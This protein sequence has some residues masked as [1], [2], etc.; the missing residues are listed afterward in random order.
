[1]CGIFAVIQLISSY[2]KKPHETKFKELWMSGQSR[3]P[4]H[5]SWLEHDFG[6]LGFHR[7]A[8]NG[9]NT[10]SN[11]PLNKKGCI[12]IC[13]GEIY[14]YKELYKSLDIEQETN[15]DCEIIIDM[16][17]KYGIEYTL[18]NLDGVFGFVLIDVENKNT[19][20]AR[21]PFGVR[22]IYYNKTID[23]IMISSEYK[24]IQP[25][26]YSG[27]EYGQFPPGSYLSIVKDEDNITKYSDFIKYNNFQLRLSYNSYDTD[28]SLI[29]YKEIYNNLF[30]AV[31]KR[32]ENTDRPVACLLSG[33]LDSSLIACIVKKILPENV[34]LETYSIG[35][36][37]GSDFIHAKTVANFIGS[38]HTE[39]LIDENDFFNAIPDVIKT[40]S[41]YD[42]TTVRASVGNYLIG[43]YISEN[44]EA[45]VIFNGDGADELA[46]GYMY[47]HYC[48]DSRTFDFECKRLLS[49][50]H[51]FDGLRS[52]RCIS[53]HGLETRT[54]FLDRSFVNYYLSIP[55][56]FRDHNKVGKIEKYLLRK[57]VELYGENLMPHSVLWRNKEAF[58]DG[59]SSIDNSWHSIIQKRVGQMTKLDCAKKYNYNHPDSLEKLYYRTLFDTFYPSSEKIIPY[60]W[61][62]QFCNVN[63][64]SAREL[65]IYKNKNI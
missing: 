47:F 33:G 10:I 11:Q 29:P 49:N 25:Y 63:D 55:A 59:V 24:Q 21:D 20:I 14:N 16:Y 22:P 26:C 62:P 3:G 39:I 28:D 7:L 1:M 46:G 50:I 18:Q 58:S 65:T 13:N 45:K 31:K 15:S 42:T 60:F 6:Y 30:A 40:I 34:E 48:P 44:S 41:S 56:H 61:M 51:H 27:C 19:F 36:P 9:L 54:P 52:D 5:S 8:I 12:L 38:K 17:K 43:K 35:M 64:A 32:V 53:T 4:E 37:G 57:S 23:N 2:N